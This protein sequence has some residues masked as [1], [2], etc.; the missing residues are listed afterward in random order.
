MLMPPNL[1]FLHCRML[2]H[3]VIY[4]VADGDASVAAARLL[5]SFL[6]ISYLHLKLMSDAS[7][8]GS[9]YRINDFSSDQ[10]VESDKITFSIPGK[11]QRG[12]CP[13]ASTQIWSF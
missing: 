7:S 1:K 6:L 9:R 3:P 2:C 11:Y 8:I 10:D 4:A 5:S 13:S 12:Y